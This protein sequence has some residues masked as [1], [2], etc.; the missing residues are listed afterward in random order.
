MLAEIRDAEDR[1]HAVRAAHAFAHHFGGK[2]PKAVAK[3]VDDLD[4]RLAFFDFPAEHWIHLKSTN[5]I[6]NVLDGAAPHHPSHQGRR[7]ASRRAGDGIQASRV[8]PAAMAASQRTTP[9]RPRPRRRD[10][11]DSSTP[12]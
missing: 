11:D 6:V 4:A 8:R 10:L 3:I 7:L 9:R 2:W 5:P 12:T 1:D